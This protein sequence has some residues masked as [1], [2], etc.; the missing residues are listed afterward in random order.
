MKDCRGAQAT[1]RME[2]RHTICLYGI[3]IVANK[4]GERLQSS[5]YNV[6][7]IDAK[8]EKQKYLDG[9]LC[10]NTHELLNVCESIDRVVVIVCLSDGTKHDRIVKEIYE[11]GVTKIIFLPMGASDVSLEDKRKYREAYLLLEE[12]DYEAIDVPYYKELE[13]Y[14]YRI[15]H[16]GKNSVSF[17]YPAEKIRMMDKETFEK[18]TLQKSE[19][20]KSVM[21]EYFEKK[22]ID[23]SP[24]VELYDYLNYGGEKPFTYLRYQR[25]TQEERELILENRKQLYK[26]FEEA[27]RFDQ[28]LF[29][30]CPARVKWNEKGYLSIVDGAHRIFYLISK[31]MEYV[32]VICDKEDFW[33]MT[34]SKPK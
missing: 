13:H 19:Y 21:R 6:I 30:D 14:E 33:K 32:P 18:M 5:G 20:S 3:N 28:S 8:I 24:Y 16:Y 26:V 25:D 27:F 12:G 4:W 7:K 15:I 34:N 1:F 23:V 31:H 10:I 17:W 9:F 11:Y 2:K 29:S 22:L